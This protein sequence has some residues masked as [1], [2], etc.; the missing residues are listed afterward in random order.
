MAWNESNAWFGKQ[1]GFFQPFGKIS[2]IK[3]L[4]AHIKG[5]QIFK[6]MYT[7]DTV[8]DP[9]YELWWREMSRRYARLQKIQ[10]FTVN[11]VEYPSIQNAN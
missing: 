4:T 10:Q 1:H 8:A 5:I 11:L 3:M 9:V 7:L 6:S 2:M